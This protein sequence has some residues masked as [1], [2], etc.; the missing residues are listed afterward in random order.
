MMEIEL[1]GNG[2]LILRGKS[3]AREERIK[4]PWESG[5]LLPR[6]LHKN[7]QIFFPSSIHRR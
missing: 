5:L 7:D 4:D 6:P 2:S 3:R 1:P